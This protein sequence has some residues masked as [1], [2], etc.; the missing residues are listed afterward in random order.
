VAADQHEGAGAH[1]SSYAE[2]Q[3]RWE[4][5]EWR[6]IRQALN[7]MRPE[8]ARVAARR[9]AP[10]LQIGDTGL[11]A[12]PEWLPEQPVELGG[13]QLRYAANVPDPVLDGTGPRT[14]HVRPRRSPTYRY[15]RYSQAIQDLARPALWEDRPS[16]RLADLTWHHGKGDMTFGATTYF[17]GVDTYEVLAHELAQHALDQ[18]GRLRQAEPTMGDLPFR[19]MVGDPCDL[20]RRPVLPSIDTLTIRCGADGASFLLHQRDPRRVAVAGGMLQ[21]IPAG[22]FQPS[23]SLPGAA[24]VDFDL[25]RNIMREFSEELLGSPEHGEDGRLVRYDQGVFRTLAQAR[26]DGRLRVFCLGVAADALTLVGEI[27][28]V[29][30]IDAE[31]FDS[32]AA[33]FVDYND[34][35]SL[36]RHRYPFAQEV[37][38]R[39]LRDR[40]APA[41]AGCLHLAWRHRDRILRSA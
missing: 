21:V 26:A 16:W 32:L 34:E 12:R 23:S 18:H 1:P 11:V 2:S 31:V 17:A 10:M 39:M 7:A 28:T 22:I 15:L 8:L 36:V 20:A 4:Q 5:Q 24:E 13:V 3:V 19:D 40:I 29:L 38:D 41:A 33:G 25:W 9:Y 6:R 37:I 27:L 35:G 14:A 30:V